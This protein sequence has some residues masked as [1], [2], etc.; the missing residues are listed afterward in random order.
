MSRSSTA[1]GRQST[2]GRRARKQTVAE[3]LAAARAAA[4]PTPSTSGSYANQ[5]TAARAPKHVAAD[6]STAWTQGKLLGLLITMH[7]LMNNLE[8]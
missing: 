2:T 7:I 1:A 5:S 4:N 6:P 8:F 3:L